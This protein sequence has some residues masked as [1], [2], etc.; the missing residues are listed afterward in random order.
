M[1]DTKMI[2]IGQLVR[3]HAS[4]KNVFLV[5]FGTYKGNVIAAKEWGEK[6][7]RMHVPPAI[8]GSWDYLL[9]K[10]NNGKN[11]LLILREG[12]GEE[13][14]NDNIERKNKA[15]KQLLTGDI[16]R[17]TTGTKG[18]R[19]IGVVYDPQYERYG[20]YVPTV[21]VKRYDAFLYID[22]TH[23]LHP[24][25]MPEIQDDKELPETFPTGL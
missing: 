16:L 2:N 17:S 19:A 5:G 22:E 8:E 4:E 23:A 24:L 20:N 6:M 3:E 12:G 9:H 10:Q 25:H 14:E 7:E 13:E 18:Q 11:A 1:A 15:K 21:L